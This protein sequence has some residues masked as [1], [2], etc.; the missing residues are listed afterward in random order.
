MQ[1]KRTIGTAR[2]RAGRGLLATVVL[3]AAFAAF[4]GSA[5]A[6]PRSYVG[7]IGGLTKPE[8]VSVNANGNVLVSDVATGALN[9]YGPFPSQNLIGSQESRG[10]WGGGTLVHSMARSAANGFLYVATDGPEL[11]GGGSCGGTPFSIFDNFGNLFTSH[12]E[13]EGCRRG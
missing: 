3:C 6:L 2:A 7:E 8:A 11:P 1:S 13:E 5:S 12:I 10:Y 4:A 9:E